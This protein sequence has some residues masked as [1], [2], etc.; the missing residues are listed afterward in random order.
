MK[1]MQRAPLSYNFLQRIN[2]DI[3]LP[4]YEKERINGFIIIEANARP[5]QLY[6]NIERDEMHVFASYLSNIINL[7]QNRNFESLILQEKELK[8][9]LYKK[10]QEIN[11]YKESIRSFLKNSKQKEIGIIFYKYRRFIFANQTA[12]EMIKINL[13]TQEGHPLSRAL[14][15]V[16]RK[17][18]EYKSPQTTM[19]TDPNGVRFIISGVSNLEQ[20]NV[21][22]IISYP[23]IADIITKQLNILK[24][25]S[26]WDYLLYLETT[27][28]GQ[29]INQLIPGNGETLLNFKISLMQTALSKKAT[30]L[31]MANEDLQPM[32]EL[33]H[34][35]SMRET[36]HT[37]KLQSNTPALETG[38]KLFGINP[39][40]GATQQ[41]S[42]LEKLDNTGTLFIKNIEYLDREL[43]EYL[44]EFI[45]YGYYRI[46]KS[47]HKVSSN[48]RIICSAKQNLQTLVQ[49]GKFSSALFNELKKCSICMPSLADLP[50]IELNE[51]AQG[52]TEQALKT[53]DFKNLLELTEK[54]RLKIM[55]NRPLSLQEL[56]TK[57]QQLLQHKSKKNN[58][59][60]EI[61]FDP[62]YEII[63][64]ELIQASRLGKYALR[65]HKIMVMLWNKF[66]NQNKI[67]AFLGVNRS[68]VN[69]R[70]REYNLEM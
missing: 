31:E 7:L 69:R 67:A 6:S 51:L 16:A 70:C 54:E 20:N 19:A 48:V 52:Y 53:N 62:A 26:K 27:K 9:E 55:G 8:E 32:V 12:K 29:L 10:H 22:L 3:F 40:F 41:K 33:L 36:L 58:I 38:T 18:E 66:R 59:E 21:I 57:V 43:Q 50:D 2:A 47:E 61:H 23:D 11:Q 45:Q 35:I 30:L 25:P 65:D 63:D 1:K 60:Q 14:K 64:P 42:L 17:V 24:D 68:S 4:I 34:H 49:E 44:A 13:N 39:I 37:L 28:P 46:F 56:K 15:Q 5:K